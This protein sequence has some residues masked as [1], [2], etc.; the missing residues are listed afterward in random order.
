[1]IEMTSVHPVHNAL[2]KHWFEAASRDVLLIQRDPLTGAAQ[3]YPRA[4]VAGFPEREPEWAE[5]TGRGT[6]YSFTVVER[7]IHKEFAA[8]TPFVIA[9][10]DLEEGARITSW[11]VDTPIERIQ[12]DMALKVVFREI[13]PGVKMPCFVEG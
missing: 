8:I 5:A 9:I 13:H 10:V 3:M 2:S 12:C 1:M 4:R 7:S 11:V 6:L